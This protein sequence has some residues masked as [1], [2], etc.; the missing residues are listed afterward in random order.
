MLIKIKKI[1]RNGNSLS[2][3]EIFPYFRHVKRNISIFLLVC[4]GMYFIPAWTYAAHTAKDSEM[5]CCTEEIEL[6]DISAPLSCNTSHPD[7]D[8]KDHHCD[9]DEDCTP[10]ACHCITGVNSV[11]LP[12]KQKNEQHLR[13]NIKE[14]LPAFLTIATSSGH[15]SIWRPPKIG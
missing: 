11:P 6:Q 9:D 12:L 8:R 10:L 3:T 5:T 7:K 1:S 13:K 15:L 14:P 2:R 4:L